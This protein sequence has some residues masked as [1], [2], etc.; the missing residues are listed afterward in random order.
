[1]LFIFSGRKSN[2]TEVQQSEETEYKCRPLELNIKCLSVNPPVY[3]DKHVKNY[4][5]S[6]VL[7]NYIFN[8]LFG[9]K[10]NCS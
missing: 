9:R 4:M 8:V 7:W 3:E 10:S 1:M 2:F 5:S 6:T